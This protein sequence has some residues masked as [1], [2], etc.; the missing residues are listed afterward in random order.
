MEGAL[1][2]AFRGDEL[3]VLEGET[4]RVPRRSPEALGLRA[5]FEHE[6]GGLDGRPCYAAEVAPDAG[7]PEGTV[8]RD[9]RGLWGGDEAFFRTAGRAKQIVEW[10]RTHR[11]CGRDGTETVPGP[12]PLSKECPSC[13]MLFYPRLSPAVI[14]LVSR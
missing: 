14:V 9:L 13:G 12:T 2:F 3:L 5:L 4:V 6:V 8:F 10:N 11:F 1:W 7:P